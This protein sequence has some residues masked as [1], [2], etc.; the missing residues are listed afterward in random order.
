MNIVFL[1][2]LFIAIFAGTTGAQSQY[3]GD[4]NDDQR[5]DSKDLRILAWQWLDPDCLVSDCT[6]DFDGV[7]GVNMADFALFAENWQK[8]SKIV[9]N[10]IHYDPAVKTELSEFVEL[11]NA[12]TTDADI[13]GWYFSAGISYEFPPDTILP[14]GGY[15][16]VAQDPATIEAKFGTATNL[17]YG[18]F[19]GRLD[20]DGETVELSNEQGFR[21]DIVD[22]RRRF[23][24][25][26]VGD[27]PSNSIELANPGLDNDLG[28]S[29]RPSEPEALA[30][31][32]TIIYPGANWR[33]LKGTSEASDP[34]SAWREIGFADSS[35]PTGDLFIGYGEDFITTPLSDM[36]YN[37]TSVFLRK[38]FEVSDPAAISNL[39]LE[40][41]YDD[42]FNSWIN[43]T[44]VKGDN[45]AGPELPYTATAGVAREDH[46]WNEFYLPPPSGYLVPGTNV[47]AIQL[48]N[49]SLSESSD[50][51]LD[52]R[53][54]DVP[55]STTTGPTPGARNTTYSANI[56]P[57]MRQ[58]KN[59]PEQPES[60]EDV[61]IT[62]KV[63]DPDGV[64]SV[65]LS[66]QLVY[67]G[68]YIEISDAEYETNWTSLPMT[69][70]GTGGD[71]DANDSIYTVVIPG[72]LHTN[73]LLVRYRITATDKTGLSIT[74][75]YAHDPQPNF[76]Y[77]VYDGVP[78]WNGAINP[79][80]SDPTQ[81]QVVYYSP[82]VLTK[83]P[84]YHLI[85][86]KDSVEHATWIDQYGGD[87]YRWNGTLVYDGEVYDHI[88]YRMRG[89]VWRYAMG[90]N[91]W[92]FDF[93][94]GHYFQ[95]RDDYDKKYDTTWDKLNFSACIQQG[96]YLHRGEQGMIEAASFLPFNLMGVEAPKTHWVHY[97]IIDETAEF[98]P[99]QY[100]GDFWGL[101]MAIEQMDGR[102][103]D[104]HFLPDG[105]LYKIEGYNG[106]LNNQ[107]AY[108]VTDKSDIDAFKLGF[109]YDPDPTEQW[110]RDN[111]DLERYYSYRAVVEG[112]HHGDIGYGKNYFFYLNPETNTWYMLPWDVDLCW[113]NTM[114]GNGE[115]PFKSQGAIFTHP[116]IYLEYHNRLRE[117]HDLLYNPEQM[118]RLLNDLAAIIDD[119][120]GGLSIIDADRAMWD[121]NPLMVNT[122][123]PHY[124]N[125]SKAGQGRF[126][127]QAA[128][129][130]FPGM[131]QILKTYVLPTSYRAFDTYFEDSSMPYTP[132]VT[133]IGPAGYPSNA[134][135]FETS[136]FS[137][138]QGND[139]FAAMKWRIAEVTDVTSPLFDPTKRRKYEIETVWETGE[140]TDFNSTITIPAGVIQVGHAYR[141]RVRMKDNTN[142]WSHWSAYIQFTVSP[143]LSS[144]VLDGLRI[145]EVM[146]N[147]A[148]PPPG[149]P[150]NNDDYEYIELKNIGQDTLDLTYVSFVDGITFDFND[151]DVTSLDS[152]D[153]VLVVRNKAA[154]ESRYGMGL[155][156][157]IAGEYKDNVQN[158]LD[159]AGEKVKLSD[160]WNGTI[161]EFEYDEDWYPITDGDGFSLTMI[162]PTDEALFGSEE[163]L[164][165]HWKLDDEP[166]SVTAKDSVG[167]ND[168]ILNGDATW[169]TGRIG[170]ALSFDG[171][172]D[173]LVFDDIEPLAGTN[174]TAQA[175]VKLSGA[176]G[177][178]NP[179]INQHDSNNDGYYFY[180]SNYKPAFYIINGSNYTQVVSDEI[181]TADKWYHIAGTN[182]G[183]N[184]RLF[185]DGKLKDTIS[186][187][188]FIGV[189]DDAYIACEPVTPLYYTG[190]IDDVRIY[191]RAVN[192]SELKNIFEPMKRWSLKSSWRASVYRNGS[193]GWDDSDILPN[194]G[195]IV[196]NEVMSHSNAGPD[197][198]EL[199]NTTGE[200]IDIGGWFLSDNDRSEPNLMKYRIPDGTIIFKDS[201]L[202]Y[203]EDSHFGNP[204]NPGCI[205]PFAL[206]ENGESACLSSPLDPNGMLTGYRE[207]EDFGA[208]MTNVSFGRYYKSSTGTFN[209]VAMDHNTP[210]LPNGY[211][212]VGPIV[213]NEIMYN[214]AGDNQ[215][216]EY[217]ELYNIT[218]EPVTLYRAD[219]QESWKFTDGINYTFSS[220]PPITIFGNRYLL[221]VK[222]DPADFM[223]AFFSRYGY[224]LPPTVQVV[225]DY[226]GFLD[227]EGERLQLDMPGD[228]VDNTQYYIRIDRV[229]Y[230]DGSHPENCAGG[231]DYWPTDAD[232]LGQSLSRKESSEYGND[233]ANWQSATPS[234]GAVN[235]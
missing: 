186:S 127:Q 135:M 169:T 80:S 195:A 221:V 10:E 179:V 1:S 129:K 41:I 45:V 202:I 3:L 139:T 92:K 172:G 61:E 136:G 143:P 218:T 193:P 70:D 35:W 39:R 26:I 228:K 123:Y 153:Y 37:Y 164:I 93:N 88:R 215:N 162:D 144:E 59:K 104:E 52:V 151:S 94:R 7:N 173:Y 63:T 196:I 60:S 227:N 113:A 174:L 183:S 206:S 231:V 87:L 165:A 43:G 185:V 230:S 72:S 168:G 137:D 110:W 29:W 42:G 226:G 155:S 211:P 121:Y 167:T 212:M 64:Q 192:E 147:P 108:A 22:Y 223:A 178:W 89:G 36:R 82:E 145:T 44:F 100:D 197:W 130:D 74:G 30:P 232:G 222:E 159:N 96:D 148:D 69:D 105:N 217:I 102:F 125:L 200:D 189:S 170:G 34:I 180:I 33:Y 229:N 81:N 208:S 114:Y 166:G 190:L 128:T 122:G 101:Y 191:N 132:T 6:A 67:P 71:E 158:S 198:I 31:P 78:G 13:S 118:N 106:E 160:F 16:V 146:Y 5:V 176:A 235:P 51:F 56:P 149:T 17:I 131:V 219:K 84:V 120:A 112:V 150:Y 210:L 86:K 184:L 207:V 205:V 201:Y 163:G 117:F 40:V 58:V 177:M 142:R 233:V 98:G 234:P 66:Y 24:W 152:G 199:Y 134:L 14:V 49:A 12:G 216:E 95:A 225:G 25:P 115:D 224:P 53:L 20:N 109:Y 194:P 141:V 99:T 73:R 213:I 161:V 8:G 103:L 182:D 46:D 21:I 18:P 9:I 124:V 157:I 181:M 85:S 19:S 138:P 203:Y 62:V 2:L 77:F 47:L 209:F 220:E 171:D 76:A 48:F 126:Y 154:F 38:E 23:P 68:S 75:P 91:M 116:A 11:Y 97:R 187:A 28:G 133:Y 55:I 79:A 214:P 83:I 54:N 119:P 32:T 111:V 57:H 204:S 140:I 15:I 90:K 107:G 65:N 156:G 27:P 50:C 188:G 4:L 175:W